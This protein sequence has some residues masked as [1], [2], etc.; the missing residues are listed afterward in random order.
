[1]E[2]AFEGYARADEAEVEEAPGALPAVGSFRRV[3]RRAGEEALE[4]EVV[5]AKIEEGET[6]MFY[7]H[8][9]SHDRRLDEWVRLDQFECPR[10][11]HALAAHGSAA[12]LEEQAALARPRRSHKRRGVRIARC[13]A[14][15]ARRPGLGPRA[16]AAAARGPRPQRRLRLDA[17]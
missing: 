5:E 6:P 1:M 11:A 10:S 17:R 14:T 7:V 13:P 12:Q 4:A 8:Y 3:V 16:R 2:A 15:P 9:S